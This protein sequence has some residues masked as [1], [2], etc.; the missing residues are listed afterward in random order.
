[1]IILNK[2]LRTVVKYKSLKSISLTQLR[3]MADKHDR[4]EF[5]DL[6]RENKR[7]KTN[8]YKSESESESESEI[9]ENDTI[10]T[11]ENND[12]DDNDSILSPEDD[13]EIALN[14]RSE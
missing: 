10:N 11:T 4:E 2:N 6:N 9:R 7:L 1:M 12:N 13:L 14:A 5:D 8:E 3:F